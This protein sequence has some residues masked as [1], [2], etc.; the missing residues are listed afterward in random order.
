MDGREARAGQRDEARG[1]EGE[2]RQREKG[3]VFIDQRDTFYFK[4][5]G[6]A[7]DF[8]DL[9]LNKGYETGQMRVNL[10]G[11]HPCV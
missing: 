1:R 9:I 10:I 11:A 8:N 3:I 2:C 4:S 6:K 7:V 5:S